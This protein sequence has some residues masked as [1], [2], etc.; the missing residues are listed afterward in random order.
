MLAVQVHQINVRTAERDAPAPGSQPPASESGSPTPHAASNQAFSGCSSATG[1]NPNGA[2]MRRLIE[3]FQ[4]EV[5]DAEEVAEERPKSAGV[6]VA[7]AGFYARHWRY[8]AVAA[9]ANSR[10]M[11]RLKKGTACAFRPVIQRD[12]MPETG[13][14]R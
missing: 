5:S 11:A 3:Q 13:S 6:R 8:A 14:V 9:N 7:C 10:G 1:Q 2:K 12:D 4:D